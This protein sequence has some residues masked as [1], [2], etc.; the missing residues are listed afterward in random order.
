MCLL[1][2]FLDIFLTKYLL[3]RA[4]KLQTGFAIVFLALRV[5]KLDL[6]LIGF[7]ELFLGNYLLPASTNM[8]SKCELRA[9]P[10]D[11]Q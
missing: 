6:V 11:L 7:D 5:S 1:V 2:P 10:T 4:T 8:C 9:S 3:N